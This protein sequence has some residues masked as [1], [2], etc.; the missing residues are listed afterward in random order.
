MR[1]L[2]VFMFAIVAISMVSAQPRLSWE[3]SYKKA[4]KI[5]STLSIEDKIG[6]VRGHNRFCLPGVPEKGIPYVLMC[7]AT[8]GVRIIYYRP[9]ITEVI[10]P[11]KTTQFPAPIML[12]STFNDALAERYGQAVG[13]ESRMAGVGVLLGPGMNIYRTAQCG[14]NFEY[15]GEDPY[16][17]GEMVYNYVIG[18][19]STGTMACLKHFLAN[20]TEFYRKHSNSIVDERAI[21][22]IY[23]PAFVR[24]IEADA[25]SVMTA[26]NQLNGEWTGQSKYV[27]TDLLRNTF[28]FKGLIMTDWN[29]VY[30]W[31]NIVFSGQNVEM[32]GDDMWYAQSPLIEELVKRGE[33]K[34]SDLDKMILPTIATCIRFNL[35]E[36]FKNGQP[37]EDDLESLLSEHQKVVY[38]TAAEGTVLLKNNGI[39]PLNKRSLAGKR[40]LLVGKWANKVPHGG[41]SSKVR[42]YG[43][44]D[45]EEALIYS[46]RTKISVYE[47]P[48]YMDLKKADI[49]IVATGTIDAEGIERPFMMPKEDESL[50]R[51]AVE[52][53]P[54]T[55]VVVNSGSGID[56]SAW[57]DKAAAVLYGWYPGQCGTQAIADILVGDLNP[58]GKLPITIEQ[59]F[60][61]S[62]GYNTVPKEVSNLAVSVRNPNEMWFI[63]HTYDVRYEESVFV[64][65]RWYEHK[66]IKPLYPFGHG[67]SYTSF[68]L[69]KFSAPKRFSASKPATVTL[70]IANSGAL[71]GAEV[72]Q[73][74][75]SENNPS[76]ARPK[77][78]LKHYAK[79]WLNPSESK[80]ISFTLTEKDLR[81]WND[82][83]HRW[84]SNEGGYTIHIGTSS[85]D[86]VATLPITFER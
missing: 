53:N 66:G 74:Y 38:Q 57:N 82:K 14:R 77:K 8:A 46:T 65:Y 4:E 27:I 50:V 49:V 20:N 59:R 71:A 80:S 72:V 70:R 17:A 52:A 51:M 64:G 34:E 69:D 85:E 79:V 58:S 67:L 24:G 3:E 15:L 37:V 40:V 75:I 81:F 10:F 78:E 6:M 33:V 35:Y 7:D 86:I 48:T 43:L 73:L 26:Y 68:A 31:K 5:L 12:A 47:N 23:T 36:R 9:D 60:A 1:K 13:M 45:F 19:Q 56:M 41:G 21:M 61:D 44:V 22:E 62:P 16:L 83:E 55:I 28:G 25:G 30:D 2:T 76:V 84:Q 63:P 11:K 54:N 32:P 39:L 18:M 29:S 42:G